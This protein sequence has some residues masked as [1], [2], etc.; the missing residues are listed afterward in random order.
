MKK[1]VSF[2]LLAFLSLSLFSNGVLKKQNLE[3]ENLDFLQCYGVYEIPY[4]N[5]MTGEIEYYT[6]TVY[7]G[8]THGLGAAIEC[9]WRVQ[10]YYNIYIAPFIQQ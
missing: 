10:S 3:I 8:E 9:G 2:F 7:L 5:I 4:E 1:L 6:T